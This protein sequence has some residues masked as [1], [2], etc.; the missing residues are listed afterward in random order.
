M[1]QSSPARRH[2]GI[3]LLV[4]MALIA[5][6]CTGA[7]GPATSGAPGAT[8]VA[9]GP[10]EPTPGGD[11]VFAAE[12]EPKCMDWLASCGV[13]AW[14]VRTTQGLVMPR[15]FEFTDQNTY[16]PSAVLAGEP[17][18]LI[19]PKQKIT[20]RISQR[21]V[22]S[23]GQPIRSEDF[24]YTWAQVATG[25]GISD[26]TGYRSIESVETPDPKTAVVTFSQPYPAW[27]DLFGGFFGILPSHLLA[28]QDRNE[29][30]KDGFDWSGG[31][32]K[33]KGGAAGWVKGTSITLVPNDAY[34]GDKPYLNS[35]TFKFLAD[36]KAQQDALI[37]NQVSMI[38]PQAQ[39]G[40]DALATTPGITLDVTTSLQFEAFWFNTQK[41]PFTSK[42]VRQAVAHSIDRDAIVKQL[43]API[44]PDIKRIDSFSTP[45]YETYPTPFSR[46]SPVD[47]G[48]AAAL[49]TGDGWSRGE[50]GIWAKDGRRAAF[51]AKSTTGNDRRALTMQII[52]SQLNAAGFDMT[53]NLVAAGKLFGTDLPA[54]QFTA[55][56]YAMTPQSNDPGLCPQFCSKNIPGPTNNDEGQ[57]YLRIADPAID[58]AWLKVDTEIDPAARADQVRQ[59]HT[60]IAEAV[61]AL[62]IDPFPD[63]IAYRDTIQVAGGG[64]VKHNLSFGPWY[65]AHT[66][67]LKK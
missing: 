34:F 6:A 35:I 12:Q 32:W 60:A 28:G 65:Y 4:S 7:A 11:L 15:A 55:G 39:L 59:G 29:A 57:N 36:T 22:W 52:Q 10:T 58:A 46:Y 49:M 64:P 9:A 61:P 33:L 25:T 31:P 41:E 14:G 17:T 2:L 54:G 63:I 5:S 8:A 30:M 66:W 42:A 43:F 40:Q 62:P 19:S 23:D 13:S 45:A 18:L 20:Y 47:A 24:R 67:F 50:D 27:R 1:R 53:T 44:Q 37:T 16:R 3:V 21:A 38:Y 56:L 51:E 26:P 48:R